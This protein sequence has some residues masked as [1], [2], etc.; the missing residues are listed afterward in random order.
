MPLS[1]LNILHWHLADD[2][3]FT[4]ELA[5]HPELAEA[6]KYT[7]SSY[8]TIAEVK[9]LIALAK[10]NGVTII[11]EFDTPGHVRAWGLAEKWQAKNITI[12][13]PKGE[14]Y[15]HQFDLSM[16]DTYKLVQEVLSEVD[17]I[18]K[19]SPYI[20]LGGDEVFGSCWNLRP[21]IQTFMKLKNIKTFGQL[22]MYWRYEIK[23]ALAKGR[24]T[25]FWLNVAEDV[26]TGP[27]D[28]IHY[29]GSQ[30]STARSKLF[31]MQLLETA[32]AN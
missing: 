21:A 13:C 5:T 27:D 25:V 2:E 26:S 1:R 7:V 24:K 15:N 19:D 3:A 28:I 18:F 9:E 4:L 23:Q 14:G 11:P 17:N 29:W 10:E 16:D 12:L 32:K 20:H 30:D 31:F 6:S 8:Y 22:Q